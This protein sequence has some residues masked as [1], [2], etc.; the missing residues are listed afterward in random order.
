M[1]RRRLLPLPLIV[2][3][4]ALV[5]TVMAVPPR[6]AEAQQTFPCDFSGA[7]SYAEVSR[8]PR[9]D[10]LPQEVVEIPS[11]LDGVDIQMSI[12]RPDV[13]E[14][15][16]VPVIVE[17]SVYY[18]P[19][20]SVDARVCQARLTENFVP[21]GYAVV[22]LAVRGTADSG[23]CM[24]LFG[25]KERHDIDQ[26]ITW[27]GTRPWSS[28]SV[29]MYGKSY[30]GATQWMAASFG[31]PHL[32]TIVP[33]SG[34]P[35]VFDLL[36]GA[37]TPDWRGPTGVI[38]NVY[39][40]ESAAF[41]LPGRSV[42]AT[43]E[44]LACP[45][46]LDGNLA[47]LYSGVTGELDPLG[48]WAQRRY[49]D[50][51]AH[52]YRGSVLL[53][54]GMQDWNVSP[55]QQ[56]PW[57]T[58]LVE[59]S[60]GAHGGQDGIRIKYLLGQWGHSHADVTRDDWADVLLAWYDHELKGDRSVDLGAVAEVQDSTGRWRT[61]ED[62]PPPGTPT[63]WSLAADGTLVAEGAGAAGGSR[64]V[65]LDPMHQQTANSDPGLPPA[66]RALCEGATCA[67]FATGVLEEELRL[68]GLP[69]VQL[70]V[71]PTGPGGQLS[72]HLYAADGDDVERLGWGQV[73]LRFP[74][75]TATGV[76]QAATVTPGE[77]VVLDFPLQP[78][79]A[80]V[81]AGSQLVMVVSQGTAHN[82]TP[83]MAGAPVEIHVG[84]GL[85]T[86][87]VTRV[88]PREEDFFTPPE[89]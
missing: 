42:E 89:R 27:L 17:A 84:D 60:R 78:L 85:S 87:E 80:V 58:D 13:P 19:L 66:V 26:A 55:G 1:P 21:Q 64:T 73:D 71:T 67:R 7:G 10:I 22:L 51:I 24:D 38:T 9:Y 12:V 69:Q 35:D 43:A 47:T 70:S 53:V 37:G 29:G 62:W 44:V 6:T 52:N 11:D 8:P 72:I 88:H 45:E 34:V 82:R 61:A 18:H 63:T 46:Y 54:Q 30:D 74:H 77:E 48:Y 83:G 32:K 79:D 20:Q 65:A 25:P 14:G 81:P 59:R 3:A 76:P 23:G 28:G 49:K 86:L 31:N 39:Y 36:F 33:S 41:Y 68:A 50:D 2:L 16:K 15:V 75:G 4:V 5:A 57:I 40:L 56:F